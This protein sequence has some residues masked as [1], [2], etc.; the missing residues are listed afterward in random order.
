MKVIKVYFRVGYCVL[1]TCKKSHNL[2]ELLSVK[3]KCWAQ[4]QIRLKHFFFVRLFDGSKSVS[5]CTFVD[6]LFICG[7]LEMFRYPKCMWLRF[8]LRSTRFI[9]DKYLFKVLS[10]V[11]FPTFNIENNLLFFIFLLNFSMFEL[12]LRPNRV[13]HCRRKSNETLI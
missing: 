8:S 6:L 7:L 12:N 13:Y 5:F 11:S 10:L 1:W 2:D 4:L 3:R 9:Y